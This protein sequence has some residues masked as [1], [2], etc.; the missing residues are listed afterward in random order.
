MVDIPFGYLYP[1]GGD[2]ID[3]NYCGLVAVGTPTDVRPNECDGTED[4]LEFHAADYDEFGVLYLG[5]ADTT[6]AYCGGISIF[7]PAGSEVVF[8][9]N[10]VISGGEL[11]IAAQVAI[12]SG[13]TGTGFYLMD[14]ARV[15]M[16]GG[17]GN[18]GVGLVAQDSGPLK[19]FIFF[20]DPNSTLVPPPGDPHHSLRGTPLG[21]FDGIV[22][23]Q[24]SDVEF[25]GTADGLLGVGEDNCTILIADEIYFNGTTQF[26]ADLSGCGG[27]LP[28]IGL[29]E[30]TLRLRN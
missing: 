1:P 22:F 9:G 15:N 13:P 19:D 16:H 4:A 24:N 11:E 7:G 5:A 28:P 2:C 14:A 29:G 25:K 6:T 30:L 26:A 10:F 21:A 20:E 8:E 12:S 23:F 27:D 18:E 17:P 3:F